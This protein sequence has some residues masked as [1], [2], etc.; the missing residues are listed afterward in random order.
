MLCP[1]G[2]GDRGVSTLLSCLQLWFLCHSVDPFLF[3]LPPKPV[4]DEMNRA[5]Y[6]R[7]LIFVEF[8]F[9]LYD[10]SKRFSNVVLTELHFLKTMPIVY[11]IAQVNSAE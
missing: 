5:L 1:K 6:F 8:F 2:G 10:D 11:F 3:A 7:I 4:S 9:P